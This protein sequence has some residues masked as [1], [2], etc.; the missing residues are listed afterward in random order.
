VGKL[1]AFAAPSPTRI[2]PLHDVP[3]IAESGYKDYEA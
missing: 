2:E 3:T 1:R